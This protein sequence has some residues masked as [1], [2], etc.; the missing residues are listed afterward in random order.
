MVHQPDVEAFAHRDQQS[1]DPAVI[2][3]GLRN[4]AGMIVGNEDFEGVALHRAP[5]DRTQIHPYAVMAALAHEAVQ[6]HS[7][8][9][10]EQNVH[11]LLFGI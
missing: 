5:E 3:A 11:E 4:A 10:E 8:P 2:F 7:V 6:H 9:T 1:G